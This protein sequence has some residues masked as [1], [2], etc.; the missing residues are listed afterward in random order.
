MLTQ[1]QI[2]AELS[3]Y[4]NG[5]NPR[6]YIIDD[7]STVINLQN[8]YGMLIRSEKDNPGNGIIQPLINVE[9]YNKWYKIYGS[10]NNKET[11]TGFIHEKPSIIECLMT[12]I[13]VS[14]DYNDVISQMKA[15]IEENPF[16]VLAICGNPLFDEPYD[17]F[18][19]SI[20]GMYYKAKKDNKSLSKSEIDGRIA[21]TA[22]V[23]G[24]LKALRKSVTKKIMHNA[25]S[26]KLES[27]MKYNSILEFLKNTCIDSR[28]IR[29]IEER[30][31]CFNENSWRYAI[32]LIDVFRDVFRS[33]DSTDIYDTFG[34]AKLNDMLI[35]HLDSYFYNSFF[36]SK[37]GYDVPESLRLLREVGMPYPINEF[38]NVVEII[39]FLKIQ[40]HELS[41]IC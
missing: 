37:L 23:M 5:G 34:N 33:S 11:P 16:N 10:E 2:E 26:A 17:L 24:Q 27:I 13:S 29:I 9:L 20:T 19:S 15:R 35:L 28:R 7:Y 39:N 30:G 3:P 6:K 1:K 18:L 21:M 38:K 32:F 22:D 40:V 4:W 31:K 8:N 36:K 12:I 41:G 25:I 14:I